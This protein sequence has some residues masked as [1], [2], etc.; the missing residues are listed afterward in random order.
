MEDNLEGARMNHLLARLPADELDRFA[1]EL[2]P[3]QLPVTPCLYD[4]DDP[5]NYV[6]FP[7]SAVVSLLIP[8][9]GRDG[10]EVATVGNEGMVGV[11]AVLGAGSFR[12]RVRGQITGT[13][14][15]APAEALRREV[16]RRG[17]LSDLLHRYTQALLV[18]VARSAV[19][20]AL[21][22]IEARCARGLL[23]THDRA[24]RDDFPLTHEVLA[25]MMAVRRASV[26]VSAGALQR[27]GLIRY[28]HGRV[29]IVDRAG[30]AAA[31]CE[32]YRLITDE[33]A[34]ALS[35]PKLAM[36]TV[37]VAA[38]PMVSASA[39]AAASVAAVL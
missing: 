37:D 24:Q 16:D 3:V 38:A 11:G 15:R 33:Y 25:Q 9:D 12:M 31:S 36:P 27:A 35:L 19:C 2:D 18:H 39:P 8:V 28:R 6:L 30:L 14:L 20:N 34:H 23:M 4:I 13:A 21:H 26:T 17:T 22:S 1:R 7:C 32:C 29:T 5:M 10:V